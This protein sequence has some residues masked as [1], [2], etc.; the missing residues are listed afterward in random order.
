MISFIVR[1]LHCFLNQVYCL[2]PRM[3]SRGVSIMKRIVPNEYNT[4]PIAGNIDISVYSQ[5]LSTAV[6]S[7][8]ILPSF[9]SAVFICL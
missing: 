7:N 1:Y 3:Q 8:I 5:F 9:D 6:D 2:Q 4:L